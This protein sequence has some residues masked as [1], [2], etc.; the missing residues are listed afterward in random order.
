MEKFYEEVCL[1]DQHFIKDQSG[2][3]TVSQLIASYIGRIGENI[4]VRRF[5][6]FKVGDTGDRSAAG[7]D[8]A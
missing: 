3:Q 6:Y 8:A 2:S 1:M 7:P 5:V 4:S